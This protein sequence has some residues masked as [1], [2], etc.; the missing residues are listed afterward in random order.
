MRGLIKLLLAVG[1]T[2]F[3]AYT[4]YVE[5]NASEDPAGAISKATQ[6][7][8]TLCDRNQPECD[9]LG[10]FSHSVGQASSVGW[11]LITGQGRLVFVPNDGRSYAASS[12]GYGTHSTGLFG[13]SS[14]NNNADYRYNRQSQA[15]P[16][17]G[18]LGDLICSTSLFGAGSSRNSTSG[19]SNGQD[20]R[21]C[22]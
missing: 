7:L 21:Y 10:D 16:S 12:R 4:F 6:R 22:N 14:A 9:F 20:S 17:G 19:H 3:T 8:S 18:S 5:P 1:L 2:T 15:G 13:S 11:K